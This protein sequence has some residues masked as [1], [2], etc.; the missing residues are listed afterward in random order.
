MQVLVVRPA[1]LAIALRCSERTLRRMWERGDL[2]EPTR[3]GPRS[4]VW[5]V[6]KINQWLAQR[7]LEQLRPVPAEKERVS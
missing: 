3:L 2:P 5:P 1:E 6:A 7:G 4:R